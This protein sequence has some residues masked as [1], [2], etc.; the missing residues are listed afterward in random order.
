MTS[1]LHVEINQEKNSIGIFS[2]CILW[3]LEQ[4]ILYYRS[5][6][7]THKFRSW[8]N[9]RFD[10]RDATKAIKKS[11]NGE[12]ELKKAF[13]QH[14]NDYRQKFHWRRFYV[15][16]SFI[17]LA[18]FAHLLR[19]TVS[20]GKRICLHSR[21]RHKIIIEIFWEILFHKHLWTEVIGNWSNTIRKNYVTYSKISN[22]V[23]NL[24]D[25]LLFCSTLKI[26][27]LS[28]CN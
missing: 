8:F 10:I 11:W 3:S 24:F 17:T 4:T 15:F 27:T 12:G 16:S 14:V 2:T 1:S 22:K 26:I 19:F 18:W 23:F 6:G 21:L 25:K 20:R 9:F 13:L 7:F 28:Y 5:D